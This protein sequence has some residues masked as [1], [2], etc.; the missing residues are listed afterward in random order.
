LKISWLQTISRHLCIARC[1]MISMPTDP[2]SNTLPT[3][4]KSRRYLSP[5]WK[6]T[7]Q[8]D[9]VTNVHEQ[10]HPVGVQSDQCIANI[11]EEPQTVQVNLEV[12]AAESEGVRDGHEHSS[13]PAG[14]ESEQY[15]ADM[16][17][18]PQISQPNL[19]V[20][21]AESESMIDVHEHS[22]PPAGVESEQY[23]ADIC[24]ELQTVQLDLEVDAAEFESV[25]VVHEQSALPTSVKSRRQFRSIWKLM[26]QSPRV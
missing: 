14:V 10:S 8:S 25:T 2:P 6:S 3:S 11:C 1:F 9:H 19:E 23:V 16:C 13:P 22:S 21:A 15:V 12:D 26:Q 7:Q 17:E 24:E 18:E 5:I 20:N 4:V